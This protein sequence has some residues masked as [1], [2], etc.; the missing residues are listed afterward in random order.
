MDV[1][2]SFKRSMLAAAAVVATLATMPLARAQPVPSPGW[3]GPHYFYHGHHW[4]HRAWAWDRYHHHYY[5]YY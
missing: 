5:R 2:S 1:R 4:H 3:A